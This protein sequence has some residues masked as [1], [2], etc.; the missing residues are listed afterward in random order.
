MEIQEIDDVA[1]QNAVI[2]VAHC[3][4]E[5][6]GETCPFPRGKIVSGQDKGKGDDDDEREEGENVPGT[7]EIGEE[8]EGSPVVPGMNDGKET[9]HG[10]YGVILK[11]VGDDKLGVPVQKKENGNYKEDKVSAHRLHVW[12]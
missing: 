6:E 5:D 12:G 10:D 4:G 2:D 9:G 1:V 11:P 3:S 8:A 7:S